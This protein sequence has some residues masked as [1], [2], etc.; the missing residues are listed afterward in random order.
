[1]TVGCFDVCCHASPPMPARSCVDPLRADRRVRARLRS[2]ERTRTR[3]LQ[4]RLRRKLCGRLSSRGWMALLE[5]SRDHGR[6]RGKPLIRSPACWPDTGPLSG[7]PSCPNDDDR[8]VVVLA[9]LE[10]RAAASCQQSMQCSWC[11][12]RLWPAMAPGFPRSSVGSA[13]RHRGEGETVEGGALCR[14]QC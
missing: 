3:P 1:V 5:P 11:D 7:P 9:G 2:A 8:G 6:A 13:E 10:M 4:Y 12:V 14:F